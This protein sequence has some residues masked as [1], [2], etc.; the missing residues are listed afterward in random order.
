M[1][2]VRTERIRNAVV[3]ATAALYSAGYATHGLLWLLLVS[4]RE[5]VA[6][7]W[8][9][10]PT[11]LDRPLLALV[12]AALLSAAFSQWRADSIAQAALLAL[13]LAVSVR[14]VAALAVMGADRCLRFLTLWVA[15]GAVAALWVAVHLDPAGRHPAG[16][17]VL[18]SNGAGMTLAVAAVIATGLLAG[19]SPAQRRLLVPGLAALLAGLL[20]TWARGA[21]LGTVA[22]MLT[23]LAVGVHPRT[24]VALAVVALALVALGA[25]L[26]PRWPALYA[27]VR[28]IG[29]LQANSNRLAIWRVAPAM[30][31]DHPIVGTGFGTFARA[32]PSYR[33]PEST[34]PAPPFAHNLLLN[35]AVET[36]ALGLAATLAVCIAGLRSASRWATG[37]PWG[38]PGRTAGAT[39]LAALL[40]SQMVDGTVMAVHTGFGFFALLALGAAGERYLSAGGAGGA[41]APPRR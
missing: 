40:A 32:Y 11:A 23:V 24:R 27:E 37:S 18:G 13:T 14:A 33:L 41:L 25:A 35:A 8:R 19:P 17:L 34:D 36:G 20:A 3:L 22:G 30:I 38:T 16:T 26:L 5:T 4:V 21:W 2:A 6:R 39:V 29:S 15:G 31:A 28:S 9:W 10:V 12:C 1:D 7:T